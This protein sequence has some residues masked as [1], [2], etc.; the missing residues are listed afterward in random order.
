MTNREKVISFL[1]KI[2]PKTASNADIVSHTGITP[3]QQVFQITRK[4]VSA[5]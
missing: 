3:H 1:A 4:L 5:G 2:S